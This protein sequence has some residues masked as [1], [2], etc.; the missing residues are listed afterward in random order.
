MDYAVRP[1]EGKEATGHL[2]YGANAQPCGDS[3]DS[4]STVV[5]EK[6]NNYGPLGFLVYS[7]PG[8]ME[9]RPHRGNGMGWE[10]G[11]WLQVSGYDEL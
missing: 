8:C 9:Q 6:P 3:S 1:C 5:P 2:A 11:T 7:F 10:R 4:L